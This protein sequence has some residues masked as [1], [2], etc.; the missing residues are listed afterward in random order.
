MPK[1][2]LVRC[3]DYA[4]AHAEAALEE[5]LAPFDGLSFV[6]P[7]MRIAIKTNLIIAK[8]PSA[9]ATT[10]PEMLAALCRL[11][12][13]RGATPIVGDSPGGP[14]TPAYLKTTYSVAG[15]SAVEKSGG[16]LND[17]T[18]QR[19]ADFPDDWPNS[20][21]V[22]RESPPDSVPSAFRRTGR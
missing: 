18:A 16:I 19:T 13:A 12:R 9:A 22:A 2:S 6:K 7:G 14:F 5:A 15:L 3:E 8:T 4:P 20:S 11:I 21:G 10:H 1:V 17:N